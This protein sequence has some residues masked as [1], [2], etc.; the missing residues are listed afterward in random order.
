MTPLLSSAF[1]IFREGFEVWLIMVLALASTNG[2]L[3][4]QKSIWISAVAAF[5]AT[6]LLGSATAAWLG[7]HANLERFEA[8]IA[9]ITGVILAWVAWF[10]HGAAQHVK[11][12]PKHSAWALGITAFFI[13]FREGVEV[14]LFLTGIY[15]DYSDVGLIGLG[16][17]VGL[18]VLVIAIKV[19]NYQIKKLPV[20]QIFLYSR[21]LFT[22]LAVY[23]LYS[24]IKELVEYGPGIDPKLFYYFF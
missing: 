3:Q 4:Q 6:I 10:C 22:A 12:L 19:A 5:A 24:G 23:F 8:V 7:N 1:V 21:W 11:D 18:V 13:I 17:L 9:I 2:N 16:S 20:K 14:V 15:A